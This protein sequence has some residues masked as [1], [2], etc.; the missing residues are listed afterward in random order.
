MWS[1]RE[2]IEN[3][4]VES[5]KACPHIELCH[6]CKYSNLCNI[7]Y[8][9]LSSFFFTSLSFYQS[10]QMLGEKYFPSGKI[11]MIAFMIHLHIVLMFI[12]SF[13]IFNFDIKFII[14]LVRHLDVL[15]AY[16]FLVDTLIY[17]NFR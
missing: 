7:F 8:F 3:D 12:I 10:V 2:W 15:S 1:E 16:F 17:F 6:D 14:S 13:N 9:R 11:N 5:N 4:I